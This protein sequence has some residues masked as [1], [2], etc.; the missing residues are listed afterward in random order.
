[1]KV[2][3]DINNN[4]ETKENITGPRISRFF[5]PLSAVIKLKEI[6]GLFWT[7]L[8]AEIVVRSNHTD[9]PTS[10]TM[11]WWNVR[12]TLVTCKKKKNDPFEECVTN[13]KKKT[14]RSKN[15]LQIHDYE[16]VALKISYASDAEAQKEGKTERKEGR[17][18]RRNSWKKIQYSGPFSWL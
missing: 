17:A 16:K 7:E 13:K 15:V 4:C 14:I 11:N 18:C 10:T 12:S 2:T 3:T 1:M 6:N 9:R 5:F 8:Q